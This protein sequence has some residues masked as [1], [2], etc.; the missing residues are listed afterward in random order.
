MLCYEQYPLPSFMRVA[1]HQR[2]AGLVLGRFSGLVLY[3]YTYV[4]YMYM[5]A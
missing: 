3:M 5:L 2:L 1:D 4:D